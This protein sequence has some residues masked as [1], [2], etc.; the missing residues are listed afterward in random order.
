MAVDGSTHPPTVVVRPSMV[1]FGVVPVLLNVIVYPVNGGVA[2]NPVGSRPSA[3]NVFS[4]IVQLAVA[5][6]HV[7]GPGSAGVPGELVSVDTVAYRLTMYVL[8]AIPTFCICLPV[9]LACAMFR[10]R[11]WLVA[12]MAPIA[13]TMPRAKITSI[14]ETP[15][16]LI[17]LNDVRFMSFLG[18]YM[19]NVHRTLEE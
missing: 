6:T 14:K 4:V 1:Q 19:P 9:F 12:H 16:C 8:T 5:A 2:A 11:T 18:L 10:S 17:R 13:M 7:R 15:R 3:T